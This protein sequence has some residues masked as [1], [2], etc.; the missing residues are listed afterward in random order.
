MTI[1]F[2]LA[3]G[4]FSL[5]APAARAQIRT[6]VSPVAGISGIPSAPYGLTQQPLA[7]P[8]LGP[9]LPGISAPAFSM[10]P[11]VS[12]PRGSLKNETLPSAVTLTPALAAQPLSADAIPLPAAQRAAV[13]AGSLAVPITVRAAVKAE[14]TR[15]KDFSAAIAPELKAIRQTAASAES[16]RSAADDIFSEHRGGG[17]VSAAAAPALRPSGLSKPAAAG[18][19]APAVSRVKFSEN[20]L[21]EHQALFWESLKRRKAG[22]SRELAR[23]SVR[24]DGPVAPELTVR[25]AEAL[26][27]ASAGKVAFTVDWKQGET[28][29]GSFR[30]II[31]AAKLSPDLRRLADPPAPEEKQLTLR[32]KKNAAE[33]E[34]FLDDH[35]LRLL[36]KGYD[37]VY[38]V[39]VTGKETAASTARALSGD[40]IVLYAAPVQLSM[41]EER[42]LRVVFID[43]K[44]ESSASETRIGDLLR[45]AGL[46]VLETDRD[47]VWRLGLEQGSAEATAAKLEASGIV[48]YATPMTTDIPENRQ[49]IVR[50][51]ASVEDDVAV[52]LRRHGLR[53]LEAY[54]D[55]VYKVG[56]PA[57]ITGEALAKKLTSEAHVKSAI[58]VGSVEDEDVRSAAQGAISHKGRPWSSSEYG[59]VYGMGYSDLLLRGATAAQLKLF[60]DLCAAAPVRGG[61][62]N[63]W[64]GD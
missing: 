7:P 42:Q 56:A 26:K 53:V 40:G 64:S 25:S 51:Q 35:G 52:L 44:G 5:G 41:P 4:A 58:P 50:L 22:W 28:H 47:G 18:R 34:K 11:L 57:G 23:M 32:F 45:E 63:P 46:T 20:V 37:G 60:S 38:R 31:P 43:A 49:A 2:S 12:N 6:A 27:G 10:L 13:K 39:A 16:A 36:S 9:M 24:L 29:M 1:F 54:G 8:S 15:L 62:F 48:L 55:G 17:S 21:A 19:Y 30:A 61:G 59:M 14:A 33:I 3:L